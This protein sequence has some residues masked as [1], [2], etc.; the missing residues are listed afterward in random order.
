MNEHD[1]PTYSS[2]VSM[3]EKGRIIVEDVIQNSLNWLFREIVKA[4]LG[5]DAFVEIID[6]SK[7][8]TGKIFA[9]QIK[10]G[11]SYFLESD[12]DGYVYR[13]E[14]KHLNYWLSLPIPT[15]LIMCNPDP[16]IC[17]WAHITPANA[18]RSPLG[19]KVTVPFDQTL[20][21]ENK[22]NLNLIVRSPQPSDVIPLSLYK[23]VR[24]KFPNIEIAQD[25]ETPRDFWGFEFLAKLDGGMVC[26]TYVYK[27]T[28]AFSSADI[29]EVMS[30]REVCMKNCAWDV[31]GP[32]PK[33]I[34]FFIAHCKEELELDADLLD[35]ISREPDLTHFSL[36][37]DLDFGVSLTEID[38]NGRYIFSYDTHE[39]KGFIG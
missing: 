38:D 29:A 1:M 28:L 36:M 30:R 5:I 17:H 19:W 16:R 3:G 32:T 8:T 27:P 39:S 12:Q 14:L 13:G 25:L 18:R 2:E 37:C 26:I 35:S 22:I 7:K 24:E 20:D 31:Y 23:L 15:V 33:V 6:D 21:L 11:H 34:L 4:D 9:V 10:C